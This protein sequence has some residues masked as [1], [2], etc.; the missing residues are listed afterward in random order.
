MLLRKGTGE[1]ERDLLCLKHS[2]IEKSPE[3][4]FSDQI[5]VTVTFR[6]ADELSVCRLK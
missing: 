1:K 3:A 4:L 6:S 2:A 5:H